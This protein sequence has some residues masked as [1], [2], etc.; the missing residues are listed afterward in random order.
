MKSKNKLDWHSLRVKSFLY[1]LLVATSMLTFFMFFAINFF[2]PIYK[3]SKEKE[4]KRVCAL[5]IEGFKN[6]NLQNVLNNEINPNE[7]DA[8][9]FAIEDETGVV[10]FNGTRVSEGD[11][12]SRIKYFISVLSESTTNEV[13]YTTTENGTRLLVYGKTEEIDGKIYYFMTSTKLMPVESTLKTFNKSILFIF[14]GSIVLAGI[15]SLIFSNSIS[16][17]LQK[18]SN[19]AKALSENNLSTQFEGYGYTESEQ[20]SDT[21]NYAIEELKKTDEL[22]NELVS[23]VSHELKTPLTMIKSYAELIKDITGNDKTKRNKDL[24]VIIEES[25][26]LE[27][28]ISD[29]LDFSKL[30]S[31]TIVY[32]FS[33][34]NLS[35]MLRKITEKYKTKYCPSGF[36]ITLDCPEYAMVNADYSRIEQVVTNL[37]NNAI[38]YSKDQKKIHISLTQQDSQKLK[39]SVSD[40]GIGIPAENIPHIF[41]RHFRATNAERVAVGSGIGLSIV[42]Q[43]LDDHHL[44]YGVKSKLNEGSTFFIIFNEI[45]KRND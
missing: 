40:H 30:K 32:S 12:L 4:I 6:N 17:P 16:A 31:K 25:K 35:D 37:L 1:F 19:T 5:M 39:L 18:M 34:F 33:E 10:I 28:L 43:I 38:N 3:Q 36:E 45:N 24:D 9:L 41:E 23:N 11:L 2:E 15:L 21:L 22:R 44:Q 27:T 26:R 8:L 20:L 29:M 7:V 42:K 14:I 13:D